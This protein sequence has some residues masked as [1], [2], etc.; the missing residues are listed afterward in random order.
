M[1]EKPVWMEV[2][3]LVTGKYP[4]QNLKPV[5]DMLFSARIPFK[6]LFICTESERVAGQKVIKF[7]LGFPNKEI[8]DHVQSVL[9]AVVNAQ[10]VFADPPTKV[11]P[12]K[13]DLHMEQHYALPI[14]PLSAEMEQ[15]PV[16]VI[17]STLAGI[18]DGAVEV[19]SVGDPNARAGIYEF[20]AQKTM[21]AKSLEKRIEDAVFGIGAEMAVERDIREIRRQAWWSTGKKKTSPWTD[22][23]IKEA[24]AKMRRNQFRCEISLYGDPYLVQSLLGSFPAG[25]NRLRV[26]RKERDKAPDVGV[27]APSRGVVQ[28]AKRALL[29]WS[30]LL[31]LGVAYLL[32]QFNPQSL[33]DVL[34][35]DL[36]WTHAF[37]EIAVL[38]V[39]A[40]LFFAAAFSKPKKAIVLSTDELSA[41]V[42]LPSA[43]GKL[44][45]EKGAVP[46]IGG[47]GL[48]EAQ[49]G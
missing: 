39:A 15:N 48:V 40:V 41:I 29:K 30:P 24:T 36:P 2:R 21:G 23:L 26:F 27:R 37:R 44:P 47:R 11:Y 38:V 14:M 42:S 46:T 8:A 16:D 22:V 45:I 10:I 12:R 5:L 13:I 20:V 18:G 4:P 3:P 43:V 49:K 25:V 28:K 32:G 35:K 19:T 31:V 33:I 34:V 1:S 17:I 9:Q 7:F 6:A